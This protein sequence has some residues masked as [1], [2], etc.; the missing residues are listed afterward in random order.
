MPPIDPNIA[1]GIRPAQ[2]EQQDP[3]ERAGKSLALQSLLR[4]SNDEQATSDA[5]KQSGGDPTILRKL[6]FDQGQ[7]KAVDALDKSQLERQSK[8]ATIDKDVAQT[9]VARQ[10]A[11]A[12]AATQHRDDITNVDSLPAAINWVK[13]GYN[14]PV[15]GPVMNSMGTQDDAIARWTKAFN[16]G[17]EAVNT[18]KQQNA[19]G[20]TKFI[21]QNKGSVHVQNTGNASNIVSV[22]GLGGAPTTLSST[23]I[24]QSADNKAT[25]GAT[26][27]GQD[28]VNARA[29]ETRDIHA[30][31]VDPFGVLG[32]NKNVPKAT[33]EGAGLSGTDYL[34]TLPPGIAS[35]V[36]GLAEGKLQI[37][38]RTLQ[39]PQGSALVQ[40]AMQYEPGT[41]QTTYVSRAATAKDAATGKI[42]TSNNALNTVAGHLAQLSESADALNNTS[43]PWVNKLKNAISTNIGNP[44]VKAFNLNLMGVADELERAYRGAGGTAGEIESWR[45]TLGDSSSPEQFQAT[46]KKG[47]EM[48]QSKLESNQAQIDQGM[49]SANHGIK[50]ITPKAEAALAKIRGEKINSDAA[51]AAPSKSDIEAELRKR[52]VIK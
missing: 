21:E 18:L 4:Q 42:A 11:V 29:K 47:A 45:S 32:V 46:M 39:S 20:A 36:K 25:V 52:G 13:S 40:M 3:L 12:K 5:Y 38:P 50:S 30:A 9:Q 22:P 14:H 28:L 26:I 7:H 19:L 8:Q 6:L 49:R 44:Q 51:P 35:Q 23:P 31:Q 16:E 48:L 17:P 10:E 27:R 37:S 41:D 43:F 1:M 15:L 33:A 34:K 24:T 2:F